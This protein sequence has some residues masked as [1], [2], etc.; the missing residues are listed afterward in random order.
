L[1]STPVTAN[2][3]YNL[4]D[5]FPPRS[6]SAKQVAV[7]RMFPGGVISEKFKLGEG[8]GEGMDKCF[9]GYGQMF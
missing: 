9:M 8:E 7:C 5:S 2:L 3:I 6:M 1:Y 4:P